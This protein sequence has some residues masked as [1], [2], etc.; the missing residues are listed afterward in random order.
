M[1][2]GY[3]IGSRLGAFV[4]VGAVLVAGGVAGCAKT[5]ESER[6]PVDQLDKRDEGLQS[7]DVVQA[8]DQM[9]Q[10][11]LADPALNTSRER[12][13]MVVDHVDDTTTGGGRQN[14]DIFLRRLRVNL[15]KH[16]KGRVELIENRA[17]LQELQTRELD[18]LAGERDDFGQGASASG[19][20]GGGTGRVQP[21]Y[22]LYARISDMPN[23]GTN[24]YFMEFTV[25]DLRNGTQPWTDAYEVKVAR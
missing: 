20:G 7:K 8:S 3:S 14:F 22:G 15:A 10:A 9:A 13:V 18:T 4:L 6:P 17:K 1:R 16:G 11:L 5:Y 2:I 25:T 19:G 12:W 23:R 21:D 24:Y